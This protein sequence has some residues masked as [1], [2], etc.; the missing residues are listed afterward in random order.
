MLAVVNRMQTDNF[1]RPVAPVAI[2]QESGSSSL[3][4]WVWLESGFGV[5]GF[6]AE[7]NTG[8]ACECPSVIHWDGADESIGSECWVL[9]D[10]LLR[11][12]TV[13]VTRHPAATLTQNQP[14]F[15][16]REPVVC[17]EWDPDA[18]TEM[19]LICEDGWRAKA[20]KILR[21]PSQS[22]PGASRPSQRDTP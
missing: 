10:H 22:R 12:K 14:A 2:V 11:R 8:A 7:M 18:V 21:L 13:A 3:V 20:C 9:R 6:W 5:R 16:E 1:D 4:H 19:G 17:K 15:W